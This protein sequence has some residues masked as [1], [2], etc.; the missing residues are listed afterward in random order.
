[1]SGMSQVP[2]R[3]L[4]HCA[5]KITIFCNIFPAVVLPSLCSA[6]RIY[7]RALSRICEVQAWGSS[8]HRQTISETVPYTKDTAG[9]DETV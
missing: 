2:A 6:G 8:M 5:A 3:I 7:A 4:C 1:M 9:S